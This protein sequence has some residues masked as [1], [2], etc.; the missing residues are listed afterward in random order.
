MTSRPPEGQTLLELVLAL[1]LAGLASGLAGMAVPCGG[2]A[3]AA[4]QGEMRASVE[5]AFLLARARG[6]PVRVVLKRGDGDGDLPPLTLPRGVRWGLHPDVPLPRGMEDT[7]HAHLTGVAHPR[8][9]V[10]PGRTAQANAWFLTDGRDA[11]CLRL[12]DT[13]HLTLLRWR[14]RTGQWEPA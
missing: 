4:V 1:G 9:T 10:T 5:H 13:G 12:S 2:P 7:L 14:R 6:R 11:L 8:I 3:L